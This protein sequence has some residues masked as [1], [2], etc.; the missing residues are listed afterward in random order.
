MACALQLQHVRPRHHTAAVNKEKRDADATDI[1]ALRLTPTALRRSSPS[2]VSR[3][4]QLTLR[5]A[6]LT[7]VG[8]H[9]CKWGIGPRP[10]RI[11]PRPHEA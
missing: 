10:A 5:S 1:L 8:A 7:H 3:F 9:C 11:A 6:M 4:P 2:T